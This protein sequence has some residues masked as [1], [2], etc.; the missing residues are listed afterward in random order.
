MAIIPGGMGGGGAG[1]PGP[2]GP[3]GP[4]AP[5]GPAGLEWRGQWNASDSYIVDDA[6]GYDGASYFCI[7]ENTGNAPTKLPGDPY[8][9]LLAAQGAPG[10]PGEK[11]EPGDKGINWRG[12]WS[13]GVQYLSGDGI[14]YVPLGGSFIALLNNQNTPPTGLATDTRWSYV[15]AAG[16][17]GPQGEPGT[18]AP[19][20]DTFLLDIFNWSGNQV[21]ANAAFLNF[22]SLAGITQ[23]A[24]GTAGVTVAAGVAKLPAKTKPSGVTFSFRITGTVGGSSGTAREWK[25]QTRRTNGTTIIASTDASKTTGNS[26]D[27][28]D[29]VLESHTSGATDPFTTEGVIVGLQ[30]DSGTTITLTSVSVRIYRQVNAE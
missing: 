5:V 13:I 20:V 11:G 23:Q 10:N 12:E 22:L 25:F 17:V 1:A 18:P 30:N 24:G 19:I 7:A 28:R 16:A 14:F 4:P 2:Q 27:N 8:W 21:V 6:V 9:A 15:A 26:I 3:P 29:S